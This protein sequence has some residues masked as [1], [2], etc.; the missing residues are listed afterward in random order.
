MCST[1]EHAHPTGVVVVA[2]MVVIAGLALWVVI[3]THQR[4]REPTH[5]R[6]GHTHQHAQ[7][8]LAEPDDVLH[9]ASASLVEQRV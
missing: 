8:G 1:H 6:M 7:R 2:T 9:R 3:P 5:S 4:P